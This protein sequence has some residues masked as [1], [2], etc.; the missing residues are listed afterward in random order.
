MKFSRVIIGLGVALG[1]TLSAMGTVS[2]ARHQ[3]QVD[4]YLALGDSVG[5]GYQNPAI[6]TD[7]ACTSTTADLSGNAGY[8]CLLYRRMAAAQPGL[9]YANLALAS[10][11]GEDSC[12]FH[13]SA[14][15]VAC[16][17]TPSPACGQL[18]NSIRTDAATGD[19]APWNINTTNQLVAAEAFAGQPNVNVKVVSLNLGGNNF[20][21]LL[22]LAQAPSCAVLP[23]PFN[24]APYENAD[25]AQSAAVI[26]SQSVAPQLQSDFGTVLTTLRTL[27]PSAIILLGDQ[28]DPLMQLPPSSFAN[29]G[30]EIEALAAAA[31]GPGT[32]MHPGFQA[33]IQGMAA[34]F[35][36]TWVDEFDTITNG[37]TQTWITSNSNIH[38]NATGY[39]LLANTYWA[40]YVKDIGGESIK[41]K[42]PTKVKAGKRAKL[43]ITT[44]PVSKVTTIIT[45]K[46]NGHK[47]TANLTSTLTGVATKVT[48]TWK[49]P[50]GVKSAGYNSCSAVGTGANQSSKCST[51]RFRID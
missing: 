22:G 29:N 44:L 33:L 2:A 28:Y 49:A 42:A 14:A 47:R 12:S 1:L 23:A 4:Y 25:C 3:A 30:A 26:I 19:T 11:P 9:K 51:G 48:Q 50:T 15:C 43:E 36:A 34:N 20:L 17:F 18:P 7:R 46:R 41:V 37:P 40:D 21:W 13:G 16:R 6:N 31:I 35:H 27:F 45:Y 32:T 5:A 24:T 38:P 8:S 39:T 10:S